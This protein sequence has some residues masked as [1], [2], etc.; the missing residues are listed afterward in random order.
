MLGREGAWEHVRASHVGVS[1]A[2][3]PSGVVGARE[4]PRFDA[5]SQV[6]FKVVTA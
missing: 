2:Q 1:G 3:M 4:F 5:L 6:L